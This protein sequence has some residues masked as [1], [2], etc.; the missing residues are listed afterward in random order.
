MAETR[1]ITIEIVQTSQAN[2]DKPE[3]TKEETEETQKASNEGKILLKSFIL[4]QSY[5][6]AKRLIVQ[7]VDASVNNYVS[8][9]EDYMA[10]NVYNNTKTTISKITSGAMSIIG[11]ATA[12]F[13]VGGVYGAIIGGTIGAVGWGVSEYINYQSRMGAYYRTLNASK[14]EKDYMQRRSG[15]YDDGKGTLN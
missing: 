2:N 15:L 14:I 12:G 9:T 1:K 8:L 7:S 5:Q 13:Q 4:N 11:G 3:Q 6:T 10:E